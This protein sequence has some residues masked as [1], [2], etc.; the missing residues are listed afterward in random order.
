MRRL[1]SIFFALTGLAGCAANAGTLYLPAYPAT[2]LVFDEAKGQ[3]V[4]RIPLVT[5]T[6]MAIR[7]S[8]DRKLIYVTTIDHNGIEVIDVATR[9]VI[10]H[11]VLNTPTKQYRIWGGTPDS[12]GKFFYTISKEI[13][14]LPEHYDIGKPMYTV[15]DLQEHK[16]AKTVE[17]P[18]EDA[19]S[20]DIDY[21]GGSFYLS[22]D[23]KYI[24]R[25]GENITILQASDFKE[26]DRI[27]LSKPE[28]PGMANIRFGGGFGGDLDLVN[29]PGQHVSIFNSEDPIVHNKVFGLARF[30]LSNR[31]MDFHPVGP[32]PGGMS[33][34]QV[35]SDKKYAYA[36][37]VNGKHGTKHC[38]FWAFDLA[39]DQ[40]T[41]KAEVPCRTRFTL[42]ISTNGK[43]LYIYG[44]GFDIEVYD[45]ATLKYEKTWDLNTDVTY[46]G[47]V[48]LP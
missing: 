41:K 14:Q 39:S 40:I 4:D 13:D 29:E 5:G 8:P 33:G 17:I 2:V 32:A 11:F 37:A 45:A 44:A 19:A 36:V 10:N 28:I 9:K 26:I 27:E 35:T 48:V 43:K 7:L 47:I 16:I 18:K 42:G 46:G 20:R 38:E 24:Y 23:E 25:F 21:A 22:P 6:P 31:L 3:I 12:T 30:D 1:L 34:V 15:I